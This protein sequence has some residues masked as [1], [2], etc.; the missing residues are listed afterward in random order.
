MKSNK[1]IAIILSLA[2]ISAA[3][4]RSNEEFSPV[5]CA[6]KAFGESEISQQ[7]ESSGYVSTFDPMQERVLE[8]CK[9]IAS[10]YS[11]LYNSADKA[12][13]QNRWDSLTL[14]QDSIDAIENLLMNAGY[15]VMDTNERYP[16]YLTT[17]DKFYAFWD[18][19]N[20]Q[21][22]A[23]QEIISIR[24]SG[25]L[26]YILFTYDD[27]GAYFYCMSY[28]ISGQSDP[29]Y[30]KHQI[31]DWE[32]TSKGNFFYRIRPAN[33]KHY[34]DFSLI[35]TVAPDPV[36]FDFTLQ[37]V[38]SAG[39]VGTNIFFHDWNEMNWNKLSFND[40]WEYLY[41]AHYGTQYR[42]DY[43]TY[44]SEKGCYK[45]PASE[46][47][48]IIMPYFQIDIET[49][50]TLAQYNAEGDYYPW[51]PLETNDFAFLW[52]YSCSPEVTAYYCEF[53]VS[54]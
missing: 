27:A 13:P 44:I 26:S 47:E 40:L 17:A 16:S 10:L 49:F 14:S 37:C 18:A 50:R 54:H 31:Q 35:R 34:P 53:S 19:V 9:E 5:A 32:L 23:E 42:P 12:E 28:N 7:F 3:C 22:P 33:D 2:F 38:L 48:R 20:R 15:D 29:Y 39:Y 4:G 36:L 8:K 41:S 21:E 6:E 52:Y 30:E 24:N 25:D 51:R 45:V 46:F 11:D 1:L 43:S